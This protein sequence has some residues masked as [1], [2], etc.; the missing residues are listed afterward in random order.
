MET[1]Q[2]EA[3]QRKVD[4]GTAITYVDEYSKEHN[5]LCTTA[6]GGAIYE[7]GKPGPTINLLFMADDEAKRDTYG[8]QVERRSS[9]CHKLNTTA[10][11]NFWYQK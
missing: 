10:P 8:R 5:A 4:V 3:R 9:C 11:G 1:L 6:W 7:D 2:A